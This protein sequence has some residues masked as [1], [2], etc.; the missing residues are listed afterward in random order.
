MLLL[1]LLLLLLIPL[2]QLVLL[3]PSLFH[4]LFLLVLGLDFL[5]VELECPFLSDVLFILDTLV[6]HTL[7]V[8]L[9]F[10][11]VLLP[12]EIL[13]VQNVFIV[14]LPLPF[15]FFISQLLLPQL[16]CLPAEVIIHALLSL[17]FLLM[18]LFQLLLCLSV[19]LVLVSFPAF[20]SCLVLLQMVL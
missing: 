6:L 1:S 10:L 19:Q 7:Y 16:L 12:P 8:H 2:L 11:L 20:F 3:L 18:F 14:F 9:P 4:D 15:M 13:L 17:F 5:F